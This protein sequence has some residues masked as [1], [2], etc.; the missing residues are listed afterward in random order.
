[1]TLDL[2]KDTVAFILCELRFCRRFMDGYEEINPA[3]KARWIKRCNAAIATIE[4][5]RKAPWLALRTPDRKP[6]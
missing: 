3:T 2:G 5:Q 6:K 1:M 4:R